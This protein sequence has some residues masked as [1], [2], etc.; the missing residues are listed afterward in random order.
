MNENLYEI[1]RA[2][3]W[4]EIKDSHRTQSVLIAQ[5][6][7]IE[8]MQSGQIREDCL[9]LNYNGIYGYLPIT[10]IDNYEFKGLQNF[11]GKKF[12]FVVSYVDLENQTFAANRIKALEI[13][14]KRFWNKAKVGEVYPAF[15][16]GVDRFNAYLLVNG[17]STKMNRKEFSYTFHDDLREE[18]FIG[19]TINVK[20]LEVVKPHALEEQ[21]LKEESSEEDEVAE[22]NKPAE[23]YISVSS[24]AL[25]T[26][27]MVYINEYKE[28]S[29]YLGRITKIHIDH[30][31]FIELEPR[32]I[33]VRTGIPPS[34]DLN[35]L[36]VGEMVNFKIQEIRPQERRVIGIVIDPRH[37]SRKQDKQRSSGYVR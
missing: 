13:L 4:A 28:K 27:P 37:N 8:P 7:G 30:G 17:V 35:R 6:I 32:G 16:R 18:I 19:E 31:L 2:A 11:I 24:R 21:Q 5:A 36:K 20:L 25:E 22:D 23:G 29:T 3:A 33:Q 15:V 26:D 12:E 10:F 1:E 14:A 9:K 34:S